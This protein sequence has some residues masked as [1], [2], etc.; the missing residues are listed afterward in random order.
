MFLQIWLVLKGGL[1][2]CSSQTCSQSLLKTSDVSVHLLFWKKKSDRLHTTV[3]CWIISHF[4][5]VITHG[6]FLAC[7]HDLLS[8]LWNIHSGVRLSQVTNSETSNSFPLS[9]MALP[10]LTLL[11]FLIIYCSTDPF[12]FQRWVHLLL[13][14]MLLLLSLVH[15]KSF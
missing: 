11:F 1:L 7:F 3:S 12:L 14:I 4:N 5:Y 10:P 2:I 9:T 8:N 15:F 6:W 13:L